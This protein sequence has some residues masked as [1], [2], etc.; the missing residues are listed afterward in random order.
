MT[1]TEP[2]IDAPTDRRWK[3]TAYDPE[4]KKVEGTA[5]ASSQGDAYRQL[6]EL[7]LVP[8][9]VDADIVKLTERQFHIG[10]P[11]I[12]KLDIANAANEISVSLRS[13]MQ[14]VDA[15]TSLTSPTAGG[16]AGRRRGKANAVLPP[17]ADIRDRLVD[18]ESIP[19]AFS[20]HEAELGNVNVAIINAGNAAGRLPEAFARVA[21]LA[22]TEVRLRR[23]IKRA[24]M[25]PTV[26]LAFSMCVFVA[27]L[28]GVMPKIQS[29]YD[30]LGGKLPLPTRVLVAMSNQIR[31][32]GL[33]VL[34][35]LVA[36][37]FGLRQL[38]QNLE[39][40]AKLDQAM[41]NAPI[42]GRLLMQGAIARSASTLATL[43]N[44]GVGLLE[45]LPS[46]GKAAGNAVYVNAYN[47]VAQS[48]TDGRAMSIAMARTGQFPDRYVNVVKIGEGAGTVAPLLDNYA[49]LAKEEVENT[50]E[51]LAAVLEPAL[52]IAVGALIG[53]TVVF[54]YLPF[55]KVFEL[56][57]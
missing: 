54:C 42:V 35:I 43:L 47:D 21:D 44:A 29:I 22:Y 24:F 49:A 8:V 2:K 9:S 52:I 46:A 36:G 15:I 32:N 10:K 57:Q 19:T 41:L 26:V 5:V 12:K 17:L 20:A 23:A 34:L 50:V 13:G 28:V 18:G 30:D 4:G 55:F 16:G 27:L 3:Y 39:F 48:I 33:I 31:S 37:F 51:G 1:A 38:R 53:T 40:K 7:G 6:R 14:I 45:A 11:K 56:L 25:F